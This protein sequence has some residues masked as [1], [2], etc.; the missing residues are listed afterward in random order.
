M[1]VPL[2]SWPLTAG[3]ETLCCGS[4]AGGIREVTRSNSGVIGQRKRIDIHAFC[5]N[6]MV[7]CAGERTAHLSRAIALERCNGPRLSFMT[8]CDGTMVIT[9]RT[10]RLKCCRRKF[11]AGTAN[12]PKTR[13]NVL[14]LA[15]GT[16][17]LDQTGNYTNFYHSSTTL[18]RKSAWKIPCCIRAQTPEYRYPVRHRRPSAWPSK[19]EAG[20]AFICM[21]SRYLTRSRWKPRGIFRTPG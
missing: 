5:P 21:Y 13:R 17:E 14:V 1:S 15:A 12:R 8:D 11:A 2:A 4:G 20:R 19:Q 3:G 6:R 18:D 9:M 16:V 7:S 10:G